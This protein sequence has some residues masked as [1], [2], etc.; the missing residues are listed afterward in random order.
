MNREI[1]EEAAVSAVGPLKPADMMAIE[2]AENSRL[3]IIL[4]Y[5]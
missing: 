3:I 2:H 1:G 4:D 5:E